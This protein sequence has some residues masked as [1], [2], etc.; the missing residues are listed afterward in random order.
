MPTIS[1][2]QL[3][4]VCMTRSHEQLAKLVGP[5]NTA[6]ALAECT[7]PLRAS[8]FLAQVSEETGEFRYSEEI[9]SGAAYE[10]RADL[11]NVQPG[12]GKRF[13]GRGWIECT[14][15]RNY[16]AAGLALGLPLLDHPEL[17]CLPANAAKSAAWFWRVHNLNAH[18][19]QG[20]IHAC[21]RIVN[22][23]ANGLDART[24]Y[25]ERACAALVPVTLIPAA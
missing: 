9:A 7:N 2:L 1:L 15:R 12:D 22:G 13:K 11:G 20:D 16:A 14:G 19:D 23:G 5:L 10:G 18:A 25:Y 24:R 6:L 21:T 8:M 3:A 17:L 4:R